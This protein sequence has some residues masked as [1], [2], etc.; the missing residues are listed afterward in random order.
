[1][2]DYMQSSTN[3]H[4]L[5]STTAEETIQDWVVPCKTGEQL[6]KETFSNLDHLR[7]VKTHKTLVK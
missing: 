2:E 1:M 7:Y 5:P 3:I 4:C 6:D